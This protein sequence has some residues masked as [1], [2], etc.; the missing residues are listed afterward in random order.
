[1]RSAPL[2]APGVV[3]LALA[4]AGCA[5]ID[6]EA[7]SGVG[8]LEG[9][10][11][12]HHAYHAMTR[13]EMQRH[14]QRLGEELLTLVGLTTPAAS[15]DETRREAVLASLERI[16]ARA[17]QVGGRGTLTNY[18]LVNDYMD[19]FLDD[20]AMSSDFARRNPPNLVP[21]SRLVQ[22]CLACHGSL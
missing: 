11:T 15:P 18:S 5:S 12:V 20:V 22:S 2:G 1:M 13:L 16:A 14:M 19:G 6:D 8:A 21:A 3:V 7:T 10:R 17:R 4:L 9:D